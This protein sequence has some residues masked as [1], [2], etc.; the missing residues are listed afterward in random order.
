MNSKIWLFTLL[1]F[2]ATAQSLERQ[3]VST[4]GFFSSFSG[5]SVS[6]TIGET[7]TLLGNSTTGTLTQGFQQPTPIIRTAIVEVQAADCAFTI[8]P[9][10]VAEKID[11]LSKSDTS[12]FEIFDLEGRSHGTI[13][14]QNSLIDLSHLSAGIYIMRLNCG[15]NKMSTQKFVKQ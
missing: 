6:A 10:P 13:R 1:P 15:N 9:N 4:T 3:V 11:I 2:F 7:V 5:G 14:T 8:S 12:S